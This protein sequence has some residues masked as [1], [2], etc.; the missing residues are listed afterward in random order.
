MLALKN[1]PNLSLQQG[2]QIVVGLLIVIAVLAFANVFLFENMLAL[3]TSISIV[4]LFSLLLILFSNINYLIPDYLKRYDWWTYI[5][6]AIVFLLIVSPIKIV[7]LYFMNHFSPEAQVSVLQDQK[8]YFFA[9]IFILTLSTMIKLSADWVIHQNRMNELEKQNIQSEIAFLKAQINPHFLFNTLN[10]IYGLSLRND[11]KAPEAILKLS[12][13]LR[14]ILYDCNE[15]EGLLSKEWSHIQ[16]YI[17]LEKLRHSKPVII[18]LEYKIE[19]PEYKIA[20]LILMTFV[21]NAFKHGL[22][23]L[24]E[25]AFVNIDLNQSSEEGLKFCIKNS[26]S[27][28]VDK[29]ESKNGGIGLLNIQKRLKLMYRNRH[30]LIISQEP[31]FYKIELKIE[32]DES[33]N[34]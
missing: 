17:E 9:D 5:K 28:I 24:K 1:I 31:T 25:Q 7:F 26:N 2:R 4:Q 11:E 3:N 34:S 14:Y 8:L 19:D 15:K 27:S 32:N 10:N 18:N 23:N 21:E 13:I 29:L 20:P 33:N 16:D 22:K 30:Q 12:A 6:S